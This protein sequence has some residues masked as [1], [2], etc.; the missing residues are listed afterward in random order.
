MPK[1]FKCE[2]CNYSTDK[3]KELSR[4]KNKH[5]QENWFH[6]DICYY[7]GLTSLITKQDLLGHFKI[8]A[9][10]RLFPCHICKFRT[11]KRHIL[12][13]HLLTHENNASELFSCSIKGDIIKC[14][15]F[16]ANIAIKTVTRKLT[17]TNIF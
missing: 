10:E 5:S 15:C 13:D 3:E 12:R 16:G 8:H 14:A 7:R 6:C 17:C 1:S 2:I 4:H 9:D 11:I